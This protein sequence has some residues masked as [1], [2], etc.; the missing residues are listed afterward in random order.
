ML[1]MEARTASAD[2]PVPVEAGKA[3]VMVTVSGAVQL[4]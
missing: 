1:A 3:S 4:R 2:M